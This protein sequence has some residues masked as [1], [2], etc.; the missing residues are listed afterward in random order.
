MRRFL[1]LHGSAVPR[2]QAAE[3]ELEEVDQFGRRR[4]AEIFSDQEIHLPVVFLLAV[5]VDMVPAVTHPP[6]I[7]VELRG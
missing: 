5:R 3:V 7:A 1:R 2:A 4:P 6:N